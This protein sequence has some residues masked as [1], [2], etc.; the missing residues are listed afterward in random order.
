MNYYLDI[1]LRPNAD[2]GCNALM[3]Q[4]FYKVHV[5]LALHGNNGIGLSFPE[6]KKTPGTVLRVHG[7]APALEAFAT[8]DWRKTLSLWLDQTAVQ[9][10]PSDAAFCTVRR[11]QKKSAQNRRKRAIAKGWLTAE[12]ALKRIPDTA[13]KVLDHPFLDIHSSSTGHQQIRFF[14]QQSIVPAA[15]PGAFSAYGMGNAGATVPWFP[16]AS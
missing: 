1:H 10:V 7:S 2:F 16:S 11:I 3:A 5:W 13:T 15:I 12:Q 9:E 8:G 4:L 14:I 6:M